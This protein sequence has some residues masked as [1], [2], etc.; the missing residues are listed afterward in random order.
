MKEVYSVH[1]ICLTKP[2][3]D[4]QTGVQELVVKQGVYNSWKSW[5]STGVLKPSWKSWKSPGI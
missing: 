3:L 2:L 4:V 1:M 5:K